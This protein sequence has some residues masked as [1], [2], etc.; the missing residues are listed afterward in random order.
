MAAGADA[1]GA[2]APRSPE[3]ADRPRLTGL[4]LWPYISP[5]AAVAARWLPK[6][7]EVLLKNCLSPCTDENFFK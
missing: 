5:H 1:A 3:H 7:L 4:G 6:A 2:P